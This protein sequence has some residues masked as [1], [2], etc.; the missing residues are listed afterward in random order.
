MPTLAT[1]IS[2]N[3]QA[4][5]HFLF[6]SSR[7]NMVLLRSSKKL[8]SG[9]LFIKIFENSF[10]TRWFIDLEILLRFQKLISR[11]IFNNLFKLFFFNFR[12]LIK[13]I[14]TIYSKIRIIIISL[15]SIPFRIEIMET[16]KI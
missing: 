1:D 4:R 11:K 8:T 7:T 13:Q 2:I 5:P 10:K 14:K 12:L 9:P 15:I 16:K 6:D 3:K